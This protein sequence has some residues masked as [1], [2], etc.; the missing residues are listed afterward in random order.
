VGFAAEWLALREPADRAARDAKLARRAAAAAGPS[1]LIVDLGCGTGATYRAL[2]PLLPAHARWCFIDRDREL[3]DAVMAVGAFEARIVEADIGDVH[4]LPLDAATLVT[5]SALLDL[6]S[7][8]W[9]RELA[10][11]LQVPFYAALSYCGSMHWTPDDPRDDAITGFFNRH[12]RGDKGFGPALGPDAG[13]RA[14]AVFAEA[15]FD[16]HRADSPWR[17]GPDKL[18]LQREL[19]DGI[20]AAAAEA[21]LADAAAW[22]RRRR[23]TAAQG[24]CVIGHLD[25]LA[26]PRNGGGER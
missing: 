2:A 3:L 16:V 8:E 7:E 25:I 10:G 20:A 15:G 11:R 6:V 18:A 21:G 24:R 5:A 4:A 26:I 13:E 1:P 23:E 9:L 22:G 17:L 14:A 12:Q 19:T